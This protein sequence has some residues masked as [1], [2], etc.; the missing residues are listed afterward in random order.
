MDEKKNET[1]KALNEI[2]AI[3]YITRENAVFE[4]KSDFLTLTL[5]AAN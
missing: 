5:T 3:V 4:K 1:K 2:V